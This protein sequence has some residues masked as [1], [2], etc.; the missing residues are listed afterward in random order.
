MLSRGTFNGPGGPHSRWLIPAVAG[1]SM[2]A[3]HM[4]REKVKL[5]IVDPSR[6]LNLSRA[7]LRRSGVVVAEV[8][9][10]EAPAGAGEL[11]GINL[12]MN[13]GD[14]EPACDVSADPFCDG[15]GYDNYTVEVV[16][17]MGFDSFTPDSGVLLA[18]TKNRDTAPFIWVIDAHPADIDKVDF[19]RPDGTPQKMTVGDYRQLSDALFHAGT[20]SGSQYE[21]VDQANR[22]YFYVLD[23]KRDRSGIL[24]YT[25]AVRSLD[26]SGPQRRGIRLSPGAGVAAPER[27]WTRCSLPLFNTGTAGPAPYGDADVYRLTAAASEHGWSVWTP[28]A[29]ATAKAGGRT[30]VTVYARHAAGAAHRGTV[31]LTATSES[32]PTKK[33]TA[34]CKVAG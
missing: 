32:D 28:N 14:H 3:Q 22:L 9:A 18:K 29:L 27:G 19:V 11:T 7:G 21:Y 2:G 26:G 30:V 12:A 1:A 17:R 6:V 24:S 34:V 10:R 5:G 25:V 16:Q 20:G 13:G 23:S 15:G 31:R 33:A 4:L 8:E